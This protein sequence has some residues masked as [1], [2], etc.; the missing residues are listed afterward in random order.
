MKK[1][2]TDLLTQKNT[3]DVI[4]NPKKYVGPPRHEY[5]KNPPPSP[6]VEA[7]NL[8][9][10]VALISVSSSATKKLLQNSIK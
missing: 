10:T 7:S 8:V 5:C 6:G 3:E 1:Y 4:F 9:E 2:V